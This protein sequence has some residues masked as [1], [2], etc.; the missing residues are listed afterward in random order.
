MTFPNRTQSDDS[1][2]YTMGGMA[3]KTPGEKVAA[4]F[5]PAIIQASRIST[6]VLS[7]PPSG[8]P[9]EV[10][11]ISYWQGSVDFEQL[12]QYAQAVYI[13]AGYGSSG[14][15]ALVF[16]N[17]TG[18]EDSGMP[19]GL[20]W[21]V[22]PNNGTNW[23]D[24]IESFY[25]IWKDWGGQLPPVWDV[26]FTS[27][28]KNDTSNWLTK[29]AKNWEDKSGVAPMIY[30]RASWWNYHTARMDWP[31]TLDLWTAHYTSASQPAIPDDWGKV[32]NPRTWTMWQWSADG[33]GLGD[34]YGVESASIDRNR[35][36]GSIDD[37]NKKYKT[38]IKPLGDPLP[39]VE[40]PVEPPSED[41]L[42]YLYRVKV[43]ASALNVRGGPGA[44]YSDLGE[45]V[46]QS[47]VPVVGQAGDWLHIDGWI[48][49][50]YVKKL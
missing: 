29:L 42:E 6:I 23:K 5:K 4:L 45:L 33:N 24:H 46:S 3:Q 50:K 36:N 15:D 48:N 14:V 37:F 30:T 44:E 26:E 43:T 18:A 39:P 27:L 25:S 40:P 47:V 34:L 20:Y 16:D 2:L 17:V 28:N 21:Y 31:K 8:Y 1:P 38:D 22:K 49:R 35:F 32:A 19:H 12:G 11:D 9:V 13:R 10:V 41:G 7:P